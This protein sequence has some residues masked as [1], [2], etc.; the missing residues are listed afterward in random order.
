MQILKIAKKNYEKMFIKLDEA[1][2]IVI[3][4]MT[5]SEFLAQK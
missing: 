1:N 5:A 3:K 4:T 2:F